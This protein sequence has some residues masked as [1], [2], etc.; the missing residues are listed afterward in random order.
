MDEAGTPDRADGPRLQLGDL[1]RLATELLGAAQ[2][3]APSSDDGTGD[4]G[5]PNEADAQAAERRALLRAG[6]E[7]VQRVLDEASAVL[8]GPDDAQ[9]VFAQLRV[10]AASLPKKQPIPKAKKPPKPKK[11]RPKTS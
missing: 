2:R 6:I 7:R 8:D 5:A 9:D 4:D 1:E 3:L 11:P 10:E